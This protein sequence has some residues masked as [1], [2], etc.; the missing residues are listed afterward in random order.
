MAERIGFAYL[1][2]MSVSGVET[3]GSHVTQA[4]TA[5][6]IAKPIGDLGGAFMLDGATYARGAEL[7]FSG[8]DFYVLG[9]GGVLGDTTPDVVS[10]AFFFWNPEQVRTQWELARKV[11]DPAK[12]ALEWADLCHSYG[13]AHLP[14]LGPLDR[15]S[16]LAAK[17]CDAASPAGAALFAGWRSLPVPDA[18]RPKARAQHYLNALREL[19]GG[20]HGGAVLAMGL[21]PAE[22][23]ALH[24]PMMAPVFGWDVDT[25]PIDDSTKGEWKIAEVGTDLA[26]A[27]VLHALSADECAEFEALV[28]ALHK[29]VQAAKEG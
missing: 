7:G 15:F 8:I 17:V 21:T 13:D 19:R 11:M 20:L 6:A 25:I 27:R 26:M 16:E 10:S 28:L 3:R 14:D 4:E 9:R 2:T 22:A 1:L 18:D 29:A 24:S 12:A 23:V 5:K